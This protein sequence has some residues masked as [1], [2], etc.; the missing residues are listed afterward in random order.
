M[1]GIIAKARAVDELSDV[2]EI[3]YANFVDVVFV[4]WEWEFH[5]ASLGRLELPINAY[6]D[7]FKEPK[8]AGY[9]KATKHQFSS[10]FAEFMDSEIAGY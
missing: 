7:L 5:E 6:R 9:W 10:G 8:Y 3:L 4:Y 1:W 2:E